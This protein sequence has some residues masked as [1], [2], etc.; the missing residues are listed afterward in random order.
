MCLQVFFDSL[1]DLTEPILQEIDAEIKALTLSPQISDANHLL[2]G[3]LNL[4]SAALKIILPV[5]LGRELYAGQ[6]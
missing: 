6:E 5:V 3:M 4:S 1:V 2:N